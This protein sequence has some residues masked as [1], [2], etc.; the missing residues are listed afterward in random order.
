MGA[1]CAT[2]QCH[3]HILQSMSQSRE[4]LSLQPEFPA[5]GCVFTES[6]PSLTS[7]PWERNS[8]VRQLQSLN[9]KPETPSFCLRRKDLDGRIF[10]ATWSEFRAPRFLGGCSNQDNQNSGFRVWVLVR[11]LGAFF[12][13]DHSGIQ[14]LIVGNQGGAMSRD[15][16]VSTEGSKRS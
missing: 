12:D 2:G 1:T 14:W 15:I 11:G 9:P 4:M 6:P 3:G 5:F 16:K 10:L 8:C 7:L 13:C